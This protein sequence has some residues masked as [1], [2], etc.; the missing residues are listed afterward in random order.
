MNR[1]KALTGISALVLGV[2]A[3]EVA[4]AQDAMFVDSSG[5]VGIGTNTP[6]TPL[7]LQRSDGTA[8]LLVEEGSGTASARELF[9]ISNNGGP[10]FI[11]ENRDIS[12]SYSFAMGATGHFLISHQQTSGVQFRLEPNGNL[13]ISGSLN[14][15]SSRDVKDNIADVDPNTVL[16]KLDGLP[17]AEWNY[18]GDSGNRHIGPMAEDFHAS[19]GLGSD[20]E[21]IAPKDIAGV[22]LAA[23]KALRAEN[24]SLRQQIEELN[25]LRAEMQAVKEELKAL[26]NSE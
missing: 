8:R 7:H 1:I 9:K 20:A 14:E 26:K 10:F 13:T 4:S 12:Q 18:I 23:A 16:T 11:F 21:H 19:F 2:F 25:G 15:S 6:I 17:I 22:A 5:N 24:Q 3:F